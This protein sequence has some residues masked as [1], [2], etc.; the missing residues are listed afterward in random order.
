MNT[1]CNIDYFRQTTYS[2]AEISV[3]KGSVFELSYH[4]LIIGYSRNKGSNFLWPPYL[5]DL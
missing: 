4:F 2:T 5:D 3:E 1:P